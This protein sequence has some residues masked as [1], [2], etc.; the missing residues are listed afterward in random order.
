MVFWILLIV[1]LIVIIIIVYTL[2]I[3]KEN[4]SFPLDTPNISDTPNIPSWSPSKLSAKEVLPAVW[5]IEKNKAYNW[6]ELHQAINPTGKPEIEGKLTDLIRNERE[7]IIVRKFIIFTEET[8][9]SSVISI[10]D[11][12]EKIVIKH[13]DL[14]KRFG[15]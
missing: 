5:E 12:I 7:Y 15:S 14:M 1:I 9:D 13:N 4:L 6:Q 10:L 3:Q 8:P 11:N 2:L